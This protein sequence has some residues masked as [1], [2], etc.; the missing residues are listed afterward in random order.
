MLV[1]FRVTPQQYFAGTNLYTWVATG[2]VGVKCL[3]QK[4]NAVRLRLVAGS[5]TLAMQFLVVVKWLQGYCTSPY[6]LKK[7]YLLLPFNKMVSY[8][9]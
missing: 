9:A 1:H 3:A 8:C 4:H 5:M 7:G 2:T 6:L